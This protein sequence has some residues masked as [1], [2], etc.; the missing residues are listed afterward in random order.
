MKLLHGAVQVVFINLG[1]RHHNPTQS[2]SGT[3]QVDK[4]ITRQKMV[5]GVVVG[6]STP[7]N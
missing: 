3:L 4:L 5:E 6:L 1:A 2:I 7:Y